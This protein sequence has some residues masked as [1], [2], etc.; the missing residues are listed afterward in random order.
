MN[1]P[2]N[3]LHTLLSPP[4]VPYKNLY[5]YYLKGHITS[6]DMDFGDRFIGN[7][8]EDQFSFLF[9]SAPVIE[10][11]DQVLHSQP[12]LTLLDQYTIPYTDW[13]GEKPGVIET[14]RFLIMPPW[15]ETDLPEGKM[16]IILDPGVVFGTGAHPTTM[17]CLK[18]L[19]LAFDERPFHTIFDLGTGTGLLAIAAARLGGKKI[20][21][22]DINYLAA[23]T[24]YRNVQLNHLSD[25]V[26]VIQATVEKAWFRP[27]D[28]VVANIHYE[29][30]RY[31][32]DSNLFSVNTHFILSGLLRNQIQPVME[33]L[34]RKHARMI[35]KWHQDGVWHT[36]YGKIG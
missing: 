18:A 11:M 10:M 28:L 19:E 32:F 17:D 30:M 22:A 27:A 12:Q 15:Q 1:S 2:E 4:D 25:T 36:L 21:A 14:D 29:A 5:I 33:I 16:P 20:L 6:R 23:K 13:L 8:Q 9:F 7:W 3:S 34:T 35:Q 24:A 26:L 31:L